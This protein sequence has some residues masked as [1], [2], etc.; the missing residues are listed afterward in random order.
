MEFFDSDPVGF[1]DQ[2]DKLNEELAGLRDSMMENLDKTIERGSKIEVSKMKADSLVTDSRMFMNRSKKVKNQ[3][4]RR[5]IIITLALIGIILFVILILVFWFCGI[6][7]Q[8]CR[9]N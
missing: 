9:S 6:T 1:S 5:R 8:E 7:F 4:K 3:Q 2:T